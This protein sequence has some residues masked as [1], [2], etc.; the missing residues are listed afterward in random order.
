MLDSTLELPSSTLD[1]QPQDWNNVFLNDSQ[2]IVI[3]FPEE[4]IQDDA[5]LY[6]ASPFG[7]ALEDMVDDD[8]SNSMDWMN[9]E[10]QQS[11]FQAADSWDSNN[12]YITDGQ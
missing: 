10:L 2:N 9:Q 7:T 4:A 5:S 8:D 6:G 12:L 11:P 3:S 1:D